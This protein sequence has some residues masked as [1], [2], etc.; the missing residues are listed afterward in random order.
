MPMYLSAGPSTIAALMVVDRMALESR[1]GA[2]PLGTDHLAPTEIELAQIPRRCE[3]AV[4]TAYRDLRTHGT[5]DLPAFEA[6]TTLYRIHHP[7]AS[8]TEARNLVAEWIDRHLDR[9][10]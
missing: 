6:C 2:A 7:E 3:R 4:L 10:T 5:A 9:R 1:P 8:L